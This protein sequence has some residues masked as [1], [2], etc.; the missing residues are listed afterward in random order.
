[1]TPRYG[2]PPASAQAPPDGALKQVDGGVPV[3]GDGRVRRVGMFAYS[4]QLAS[5]DTGWLMGPLVGNRRRS[6][7]I[8]IRHQYPSATGA[9][10]S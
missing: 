8:S 4:G 5:V 7:S 2:M 9:D 10:P 6:V 1:M 3:V